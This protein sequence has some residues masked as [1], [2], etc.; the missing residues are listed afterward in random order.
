MP[1][2]LMTVGFA[3]IIA[4]VAGVYPAH[5]AANLNPVEALRYE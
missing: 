2:V 5:Q 4:V 1:D 3:L